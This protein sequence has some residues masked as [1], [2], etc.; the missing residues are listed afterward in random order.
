M[1]TVIWTEEKK[2]KAIVILTKYFEKYSACEVIMQSDNAQIEALDL[3]CDIVD[4][5]LI[6]HEG[7]IWN[8]D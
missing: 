3:V 7:I 4:D 1:N 8:E 2:E 6:E 5:V